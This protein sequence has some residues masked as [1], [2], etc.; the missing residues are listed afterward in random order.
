MEALFDDLSVS[1]L[2]FPLTR[3]T[4]G[5]W[6]KQ[7]PIIQQRLHV[8]DLRD[9]R[10][11]KNNTA[12]ILQTWGSYGMK[13]VA[14]KRYRLSPRLV[15]FNLTKVLSTL[16][17]LDLRTDDD[18]SVPYIQM[19][20]NPRSLVYDED[21]MLDSKALL[22]TEAAL[23]SQFRQIHDLGSDAAGALILKASQRAATRRM[24]THRLTIIWGPPG[25]RP[26][27]RSTHLINT[28]ILGTGKTY[29]V[30]LSLLRLFDLRNRLSQPNGF[31]VFV[32]AMTHAA[33]EA[34]LSK[35]A[36]LAEDYRRIPNL[37]LNWLDKLQIEHVLKGSDHVAP[38]HD[39]DYIYAG[40]VFQVCPID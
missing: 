25:R 40:T 13:L 6:D 26:T 21:Y 2:I 29:T 36:H 20:T 14:G 27:S 24:L 11:E 3:Y 22:A 5:R 32:T 7:H 34:C 4:K 17:E 16:F 8:A 30:A 39:R 38:R 28:R 12:V 18:A 31:V 37:P 33:I 23:Q 1:G 19:I 10:I 15:D 35:L 9:I